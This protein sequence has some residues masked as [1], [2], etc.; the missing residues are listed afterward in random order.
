MRKSLFTGFF[1]SLQRHGRSCGW[2]YATFRH[3][4]LRM[5]HWK[6]SAAETPWGNV[7]VY[8]YLRD[9]SNICQWCCFHCRSAS[10]QPG[11]NIRSRLVGGCFHDSNNG[12]WRANQMSASGIAAI[13]LS[14]RP[15]VPTWREA[16]AATRF[17][18]MMLPGSPPI[19]EK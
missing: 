11:T 19:E 10:F 14:H 1:R 5:L 2:Y 15:G 18:N 4:F 6:T 7:K 9:Y 3:L 17:T 13:I 12:S 16:P 8:P